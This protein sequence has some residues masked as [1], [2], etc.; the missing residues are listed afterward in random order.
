M[1]QNLVWLQRACNP[2]AQEMEA[3]RSPAAW[4]PVR[5]EMLVMSVMKSLPSTDRGREGLSLQTVDFEVEGSRLLDL[6]LLQC[7]Q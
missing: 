2:S 7:Q 4:E 5:S 1:C 6:V 3:E